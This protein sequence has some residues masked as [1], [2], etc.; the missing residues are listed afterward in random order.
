MIL[1][2]VLFGVTHTPDGPFRRPHPAFWRLILCLSIVYELALVF[3]LFQVRLSLNPH[4]LLNS[5]EGSDRYEADPHCFG[6]Q[7]ALPGQCLTS[8]Q[9]VRLVQP[10][11][12]QHVGWMGIQFNFLIRVSGVGHLMCGH[13]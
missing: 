2:F 7:G 6:G 13:V 1:A 5:N 3:L 4:A 9:E 10:N 12:V 8:P 11:Y